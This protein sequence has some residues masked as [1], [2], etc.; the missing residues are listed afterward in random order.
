MKT[1]LNIDDRLFKAA[2]RE[3]QKSGK[4]L[5][6][7]ITAWARIGQQALKRRGRGGR[8]LRTVNLGGPS[9]IDLS[10][11]RDWMDSLDE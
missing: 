2:R 5:S 3:A 1:S 8:K 4:N 11:R 7:T 6:E 10:S 9:S